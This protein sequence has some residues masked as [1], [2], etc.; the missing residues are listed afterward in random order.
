MFW[1]A[2]RYLVFT[3]KIFF[4]GKL[5]SWNWRHHSKQNII[6]GS[7]K[8][9]ISVLTT[10]Q[11]RE[12]KTKELWAISASLICG[13]QMTLISSIRHIFAG[14]VTGFSD[15]TSGTPTRCYLLEHTSM[16]SKQTKTSNKSE[17]FQREKHIP[18]GQTWR[19]F[20]HLLMQWKWKAWL[21]TPASINIGWD[22]VRA[23]TNIL[24]VYFSCSNTYRIMI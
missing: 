23:G 12:K 13:N 20:S 3:T 2:T 18:N 7:V 22:L 19:V 17:S 1:P 11:Q 16:F 14:T 24:C 5:Y 21:Q 4:A 8:S 6:G 9:N 10:L 15:H